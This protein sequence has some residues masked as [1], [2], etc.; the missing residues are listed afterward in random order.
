[1]STHNTDGSEQSAPTRRQQLIGVALVIAVAI[2]WVVSAEFI[3]YIFDNGSS[4][5]NKP[6]AL[7][8]VSISMFFV[9][10][11]GFLKSS[12][13]SAFQ[14][15]QAYSHLQQ[16]TGVVGV[17]IDA[18]PATVSNTFL[19]GAQ[20]V[21]L[22]AILAPLFFICIWTFNLGLAYTSVTSSSIIATLT[23]LF[24]LVLGIL[25]GIEKF[26]A[27]KCVAA[28]L[29]VAGAIIIILADD[30]GK[31]EAGSNRV[32]GDAVSII[33]AFIYAA[34]TTVLKSNAPSEGSV[35][36]AML[37]SFIGIITASVAWPGMVALDWIGVEEFEWPSPRTALLLL[38]NA[39]L[40]TV[41]SDF[42]WALSVV[43]T[44]PLMTTLSLSLT[45][46]LSILLDIVYGRK[47]FSV[48]YFVGA[49]LVFTGFILVNIAITFSRRSQSK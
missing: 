4:K 14:E 32:L 42:L 2:I 39:L 44:T 20:H 43:L 34:Y 5:Y 38:I 33:S 15:S 18:T 25:T 31:G 29:S 35:N 17:T 3:Q 41:L 48:R 27:T 12:W 24:T 16:S 30:G 9:F 6:Y 23:S 26:S 37:L 46:P 36:V 11:L 22:A 28:C 21:R 13:R 45:V 10:L 1:M 49:S 47:S 8:Y 40:G 7:S 19:S